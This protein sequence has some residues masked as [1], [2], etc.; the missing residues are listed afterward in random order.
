M[1][2]T[3]EELVRINK[4]R[5]KVTVS[6]KCNSCDTCRCESTE[7]EIIDFVDSFMLNYE[8]GKI[9]EAREILYAI[10]NNFGS[11]FRSS[12]Y[13]SEVLNDE[14]DINLTPSVVA[15]YKAAWNR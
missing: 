13:I 3:I 6:D 10:F 1:I 14:Y 5:N 7:E 11:D 2:K 12:E 15:A 8:E 4:L 9:I